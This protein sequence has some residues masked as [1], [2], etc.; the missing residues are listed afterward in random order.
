MFCISFEKNL[1]AWQAFEEGRQEGRNSTLR[2]ALNLE[3][4]EQKIA[5]A[6]RTMPQQILMISE[7]LLYSGDPVLVS[8]KEGSHCFGCP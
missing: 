5:K 8:F 2:Q 6:G 7:F 1:V 4:L 3:Q